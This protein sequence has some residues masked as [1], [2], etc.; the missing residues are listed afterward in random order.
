MNE[1]N[2]RRGNPETQFHSGEGSG[3]GAVENGRK[4]GE[5]RRRKADIR[6][7]VQEIL[8]NT[9]TD[10]SG[11]KL[12]GVDV[13]A[14]NLFQ[15]AVDRKNRQN[16]QAMRLLLELYGQDKSPED[17]KK[18][19]AEIKLL[20]AKLQFYSGGDETGLKKLDE[21]LK[22]MRESAEGKEEK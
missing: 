4:S 13:L 14:T 7:S 11:A 18:I 2:L 22:G 1:E 21:I 6:K 17:K 8:N 9:Y 16:I 20:E 19:K 12:T 3:R 5:A 15:I 10:K